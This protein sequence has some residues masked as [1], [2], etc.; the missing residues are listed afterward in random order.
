[1]NGTLVHT[2]LNEWVRR[3]WTAGGIVGPVR[4]AG[5][6]GVDVRRGRTTAEPGPDDTLLTVTARA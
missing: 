5:Y 6:A 1:M 2:E 3:F 4:A